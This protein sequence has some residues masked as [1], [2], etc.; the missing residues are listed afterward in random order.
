MI[1][2]ISKK[3]SGK[4]IAVIGVLFSLYHIVVLNFLPR[5]A[6]AFRSTHLLL[7]LLLVHLIYPF[8]KRDKV[9]DAPTWKRVVNDCINV[10]FIAL[11][12]IGLGCV[13]AAALF[14]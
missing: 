6:M 7:I 12:V 3:I 2:N 1:G 9:K 13:I 14:S 4:L 5:P 8:F 10:I 11:V